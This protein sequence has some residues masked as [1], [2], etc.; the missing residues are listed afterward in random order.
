MRKAYKDNDD[1]RVMCCKTNSAL[2][3]RSVK[4]V[5][6]L[7]ILHLQISSYNTRQVTELFKS[8]TEDDLLNLES[9]FNSGGWSLANGGDDIVLV[10]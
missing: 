4:F 8:G 10:I 1:S 9:K 3:R 2:W 6:F 7:E 5:Q